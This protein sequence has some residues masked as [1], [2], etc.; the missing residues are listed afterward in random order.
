MALELTAEQFAERAHD[1]NLIDRRR[2]E[3]SWSELGTRDIPLEDFI[4]FLLRKQLLTQLQ[5]ERLQS[6]KKEVFFYGKYKLQYFL[7]KGSFARV[8]RAVHIDS[9]QVFAVKV[10][11]N[12]IKGH[13]FID[14]KEIIE[15]FLREA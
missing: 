8:Y 5:V 14:R 2:L 12:Q 13:Q 15:Q 11:R 9:Q 10:L 4:S 1:L 6:E 3:M 7:G